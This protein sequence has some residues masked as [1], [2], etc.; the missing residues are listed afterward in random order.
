MESIVEL[1]SGD[2]CQAE[3]IKKFHPHVTYYMVDIPPV[4]YV[5]GQCMEAVFPAAYV[6]FSGHAGDEPI[7]LPPG[8]IGTFGN[9]QLGQLRPRGT[10]L[11]IS[12]ASLAEMHRS[13]VENYLRIAGRFA[14]WVYLMQVMEG[15]RAGGAA[16]VA[17]DDVIQLED[18]VAGLGPAYEMI[19]REPAM[20]V[21]G[22]MQDD[23]TYENAVW[24]RRA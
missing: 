13:S 14:D 3:V 15:R 16:F 6:P 8:S 7:E 9:W 18:Y 22:P 1:G 21:F 23:F 2:G 4:L 11:F 12:C 19:D 10:T 5:G 20:D 24:K 17:S